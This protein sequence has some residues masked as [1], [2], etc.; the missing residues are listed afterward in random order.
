MGCQHYRTTSYH[1]QSNGMIERWHRTLKAALMCHESN[2]WCEILPIVLLGLRTVHKE[3]I[4]V[5]PAEMLYGQTLR[6][7][8]ELISES[9]HQ[10]VNEHEFITNLCER[11]R[12]VQYS[13]ISHHSVRSSFV[14]EDLK[15]CSHV[16]IRI[17]AVKPP[18]TPPFKGPFEALE[19]GDKFFKL[20]VN[21]KEAVISIDRLKA[22]NVAP[23]D[24]VVIKSGSSNLAIKN[25][26]KKDYVTRFGRVV[27]E[28]VRF[29][30]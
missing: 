17:D 2:S 21:G 8:G 16:F 1:P 9:L 25:T 11:M 29:Q 24:E 28:P 22:V 15:K 13:P 5:S 12:R 7:P 6:L 23:P 14:Q 10:D 27:R 26:K 3:D 4:G 20:L 18:L 19:R 30:S